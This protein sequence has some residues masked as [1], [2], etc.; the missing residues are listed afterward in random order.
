MKKIYLVALS[1]IVTLCA[2]GQWTTVTP[3]NEKRSEH[4]AVALPTGNVLVA[5]GW[6]LVNSK[7]AEVYN[8]VANTWTLVGAMS[9]FHSTAAATI[10]ANGNVLIVGGYDGTSNT[11]VCELYDTTTK[12]WTTTGSLANG[13]SYHTATLLTNGKVLVVGGYNGTTN[14]T[15]CELYDPVAKTWSSAGMLTAGRSYHTATLMASGKVLV[16]GGY[17]STSFQLNSVEIYDP[18]TNTW[19]AGATMLNVRSRHGASLLKDGKVMVSGGEFFNGGSPFAYNGLAT[20]EVYNPATSTWTSVATMP[21]GVCYNNQHTLP[22]GRVVVVAGVSKTDYGTTFKSEAGS[23]YLYTPSSDSW[24]NLALNVDGRLDF[25]SAL[26]AN[27]KVVVTGNVADNSA[28]VLTSL[29]PLSIKGFGENAPLAIYPNPTNGLLFV[30]S[31]T[32]LPIEKI[33][34]CD[35]LGKV[36]PA[37]ISGLN[38]NNVVLNIGT[39]ASGVYFVKIYTDGKVETAKIFVEK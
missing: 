26:M 13:R 19:A 29:P 12:T 6:N 38:T 34:I 10:L 14:L 35:V 18:A 32:N 31:K 7:T 4:I 22:D 30:N 1:S 28:E 3:M 23:S 11:G 33:E 37:T 5:G 9:A 2:A 27:G 17:N 8:P 25:A 39:Q 20:A 24:I 21:G 36:V 16:A 15:Q